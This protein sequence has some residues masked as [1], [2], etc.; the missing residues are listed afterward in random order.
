MSEHPEPDFSSGLAE[1]SEL[2]RDLLDVLNDHHRMPCLGALLQVIGFVLVS[3]Q[4]TD[5]REKT[6]QQL[7]SAL[8]A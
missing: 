2:T 5:C 1:I 8:T 4:C 6:T 7:P 3:I